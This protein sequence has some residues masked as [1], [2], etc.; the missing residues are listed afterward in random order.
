M[1]DKFDL[2][3]YLKPTKMRWVISIGG[4]ILWVAVTALLVVTGHIALSMIPSVLA[5]FFFTS[6]PISFYEVKKAADICWGNNKQRFAIQN[7]F[8]V[9]WVLDG[10]DGEMTFG[11]TYFYK[12]NSAKIRIYSDIKA[13]YLIKQKRGNYQVT[14]I[15]NLRKLDYPE[16][17]CELKEETYLAD[18][19][20]LKKH[21]TKMNKNI[22]CFDS[23][24]DYMKTRN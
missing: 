6:A 24:E 1:K 2:F 17:L 8:K 9:G 19:D 5:L 4:G 22:K 16:K 13:M 18:Y 11:T 12:K 3:N 14:I 7:D 21:M 23:Y 10:A 20:K 15:T